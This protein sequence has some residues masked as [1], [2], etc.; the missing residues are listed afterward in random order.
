MIHSEGKKRCFTNTK[1][2]RLKVCYVGIPQ[3]EIFQLGYPLHPKP[4]VQ[5][6]PC[7]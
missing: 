6:V 1:K 7:W 3:E 5:G 4:D 2:E